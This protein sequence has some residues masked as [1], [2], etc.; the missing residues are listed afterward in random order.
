MLSSLLVAL[1]LIACLYYVCTV[2]AAW[3]L[4]RWRPTQSSA[5]VPV[6][7]LKPLKGA[8]PDLYPNLAS[9]CR[10]DYPVFQLLFGIRDPNDPAVA[11]VE[12][13][14]RNFPACDITLVVGTEIIGSNHKVSTLHQLSA[15]AKYDVFVISDGD[16]Q[17]AP[18]YLQQVTAPLGDPHIG[19]VTCL[20]RSATQRPF[21][22]LL[23]SV[24]INTSFASSVLVASQLEEPTYAFGATMAVTRPCLQAI[25]GFAMLADYLADDYYL[26]NFATQAGYRV[27]IIP[28]VVETYPDVTT[29]S[30]LLHH[31]LRWARTQRLCRPYGYMGM[32]VTYGTVWAVLGLCPL[33]TTPLL[34]AL[35]TLTLG[36]RFLSVVL[37]GQRFLGGRLP[38]AT[39]SLVPFSDL[40]SF[41]I[42]CVS[43]WG[44][45]VR[46]REYTFRVQ[47]NGTMIP[48]GKQDVTYD[49]P[50]QPVYHQ[51]NEA[52]MQDCEAV[53]ALVQM[54]AVEHRISSNGISLSPVYHMPQRS[55]LNHQSASQSET[56]TRKEE[57][58]ETALPVRL[59]VRLTAQSGDIIPATLINLSASGLLVSADVRF[60]AGLPPQLGAVFKIAFFFEEIVIRDADIQ[61]ERIEERSRYT[62]A[63]GCSFCALPDE[64]RTMLRHKISAVTEQHRAS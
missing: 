59:T 43:L 16:V 14:Q 39:Y 28:Y 45:T 64:I 21:P 6:S 1:L 24:L 63:L 62:V 12:R 7:I 50:M 19:V 54:E 42:W 26:G 31:Q 29:L 33:W 3:R 11:V 30:D 52:E 18:D 58:I 36:V 15:V 57:R 61:V 41:G 8:T 60:S 22:A 40:L 51:A 38:P 47:P 23:E 2:Y 10:L 25:G 20:Y 55:Y 35:S 37:V 13:L 53:P 49:Q 17:V 4:F 34:S 27:Q 9:F 56:L 48:L 32:A 46:W 5:A 44:D